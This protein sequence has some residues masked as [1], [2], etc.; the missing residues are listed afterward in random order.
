VR[1]WMGGWS[2][3]PLGVQGN[4]GEAIVG[5]G[6]GRMYHAY[7]PRRF[8][9]SQSTLRASVECQH[10]PYLIGPNRI[11]GLDPETNDQ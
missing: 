11:K 9:K 1:C 2:V 7:V 3:S 10:T 8:F 4:D 5:D 6:V